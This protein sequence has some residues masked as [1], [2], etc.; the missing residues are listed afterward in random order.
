MQNWVMERSWQ[1]DYL[2]KEEENKEIRMENTISL[3]S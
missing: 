1:D 3:I 2:Y